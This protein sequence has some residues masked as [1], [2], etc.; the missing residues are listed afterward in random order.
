MSACGA[1]G[2]AVAR[3]SMTRVS[4]APATPSTRRRGRGRRRQ[5]APPASRRGSMRAE[6]APQREHRERDQRV[7]GRHGE[8]RAERQRELAMRGVAEPARQP[9]QIGEQQPVDAPERGRGYEGRTAEAA[10][11]RL[12]HAEPHDRRHRRQRQQVGRQRHELHG[13]EVVGEQ[14]RRGQQRRQ[15]DGDPFGRE[16]RKPARRAHDPAGQRADAGHRGERELPA[17]VARHARVGEQ[18]GRDREQQHV[19][20]RRRPAGDRRRQPRQPHR[21]GPLERWAGAGERHVQRHAAHRRPRAG[22][23]RRVPRATG[24]AAPALRAASRSGRSPRAGARGPSGGSRPSRPARLAGPRRAP[25]PPGGRGLARRAPPRRR[26]PR[27]PE[28]RPPRRP[29]RHGCAP[30]RPGESTASSK[31]IPRRRR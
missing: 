2:G 3:Q 25:C 1:A 26:A 20:A 10:Q 17:R 11:R 13:A 4:A 12:Q 22:P 21:P 18:R 23:A 9:A 28:A 31:R 30:S 8:R 14:R 5:A 15:R 7:G 19:P 27:A 29:A 6:A 24:A 16:P